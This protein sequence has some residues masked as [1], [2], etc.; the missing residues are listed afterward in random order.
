MGHHPSLRRQ[1]LATHVQAVRD[2][3]ELNEEALSAR[4]KGETEDW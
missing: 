1:A 3:I 2:L 4:K